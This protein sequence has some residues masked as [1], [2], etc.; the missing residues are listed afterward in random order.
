MFVWC[1]SKVTLE[2]CSQSMVS[3]ICSFK[4]LPPGQRICSFWSQLFILNRGHSS[5]VHRHK[6][7]SANSRILGLLYD[8]MDSQCLHVVWQWGWHVH[9]FFL[10]KYGWKTK[11]HKRWNLYF[12]SAKKGC[13]LDAFR[14]SRIR[15]VHLHVHSVF[16]QGVN[17][18][19]TFMA[20]SMH[21]KC[22]MIPPAIRRPAH[23]KP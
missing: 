9:D 6:G 1:L 15:S 5:R 17:H 14:L 20:V 11:R 18:T 2:V 16:L 4:L 21:A 3:V 12:L 13:G 8:T 22:E 7:I 10:T 23:L 19:C